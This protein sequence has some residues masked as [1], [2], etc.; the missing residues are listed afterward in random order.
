MARPSKLSPE[1]WAEVERRAAAGEG[2][3]ALAREFGVDEAAIRR[4]VNPQTPQ[5]RAVAEKLADAQTAL[6]ALPIPQQYIAVNLA[7]KL[8]NISQSLASAAEL[9][10]ATAH[11]LHALA[12]AEV[13]KVDDAEPLASLENLR[14]VGVLTK[15]ANE[16]ATIPLNLL[17]ANKETVK[18]LN[19][20]PAAAVPKRVRVDVMDA[21]VPEDAEAQ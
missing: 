2:V 10:A 20:D 17:A 4:R 9:G 3:R 16:S 18:K 12:N 14:S 7:E 1:Q 21:S 11:R 5:V 19:D 13:S 15:L 6:A 8:R